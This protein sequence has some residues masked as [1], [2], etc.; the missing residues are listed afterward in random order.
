MPLGDV[1]DLPSAPRDL[2][3]LGQVISSDNLDQEVAGDQFMGSLR[4]PWQSMP[5]LCSSAPLLLCRYKGHKARRIVSPGSSR[6]A[7]SCSGATPPGVVISGIFG[8]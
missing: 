7:R 1:L 6:G 4:L 2:A 3:H 5:R 8:E